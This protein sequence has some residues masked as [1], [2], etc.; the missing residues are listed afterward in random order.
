MAKSKRFTPFFWLIIVLVLV[1]AL[2][3]CLMVLGLVMPPSLRAVG[4]RV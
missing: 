4:I 3:V 2:G 1:L